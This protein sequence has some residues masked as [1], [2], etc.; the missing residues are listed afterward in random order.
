L[1]FCLFAGSGHGNTAIVVP[2]ER[3]PLIVGDL[4]QVFDTSDLPDG[5]V[6]LVTGIRP[7]SSRPSRNTM[8]RWNLVFRRRGQ[9]SRRQG[10]FHQNLK[11][12]V[13]QRGRAIDWFDAA[14][15]AKG[16]LF[17]GTRK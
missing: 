4:Y 3:Y 15:K 10:S 2:S 13:H 5:A 9:R 6:N 11:Q 17:L 16:R 12:G 14:S 7:N 8:T 1:L